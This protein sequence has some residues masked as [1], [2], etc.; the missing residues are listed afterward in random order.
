MQASVV[1][2][3]E[4]QSSD[5]E[6]WSADSDC[7]TSEQLEGFHLWTSLDGTIWYLP[8]YFRPDLDKHFLRRENGLE[9]TR[10]P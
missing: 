1:T 3:N 6:Y 9:S 4:T 8:C 10:R 5:D 7:E 2:D